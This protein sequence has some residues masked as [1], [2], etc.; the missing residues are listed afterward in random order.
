MRCVRVRACHSGRRMRRAL[1]PAAGALTASAAPARPPR[2]PARTRL[3][4][5]R[6]LLAA[7]APAL[8]RA[9]PCARPAAHTSAGWCGTRTAARAGRGS[10]LAAARATAL[11][12]RSS[13]GCPC[14]DADH[15]QGLAERR[16]TDTTARMSR[17]CP[18]IP[19]WNLTIGTRARCLHAR[20]RRCKQTSV[21]EWGWQTRPSPH[22]RLSG[23]RTPAHALR[24]T[25]QVIPSDGWQ[26]SHHCKRPGVCVRALAAGRR[27]APLRAR[28]G[29][30]GCGRRGRRGKPHGQPLGALPAKLQ[31]LLGGGLGAVGLLRDVAALRRHPARPAGPVVLEPNSQAALGPEGTP[32][33]SA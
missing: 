3:A 29:Q 22:R 14:S 19:A 18:G 26:G 25:C 20:L 15:L 16:H 1:Q 31:R 10:R 30:R 12:R 23:V 11:P 32:A 7:Q 8:A 27:R 21:L 6:R 4:T 17:R 33:V 24:C 2:Y 13:A 9:H 5:K 28:D